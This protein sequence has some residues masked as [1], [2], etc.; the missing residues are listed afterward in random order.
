MNI[1]EMLFI[2]A[3]AFLVQGSFIAIFK[4]SH[5]IEQEMADNDPKVAQKIQI[6]FLVGNL[7]FWG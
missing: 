1:K 4:P 5:L 6:I 3:A 7:G 2:I